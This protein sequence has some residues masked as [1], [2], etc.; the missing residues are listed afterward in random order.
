MEY[1]NLF[2]SHLFTPWRIRFVAKTPVSFI[3]SIPL[4]VCPSVIPHY[5]RG[6]PPPLEGIPRNLILWTFMGSCRDK[7]NFVKIQQVYVIVADDIKWPLRALCSSEVVSDSQ[8]SLG[9]KI[10]ARTPHYITL[11]VHC[12]SCNNNMYG[13][14]WEMVGNIQIQFLPVH[15]YCSVIHLIERRNFQIIIW[16]HLTQKLPS[17][18]SQ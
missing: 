12:L 8:D 16:S 15:T 7:P 5:Q 13:R 9:G 3:T 17:K 14:I 1:N 2:L 18:T 11:Y 6:S 10:I 4:S